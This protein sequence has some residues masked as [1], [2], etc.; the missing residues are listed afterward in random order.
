MHTNIETYWWLFQRSQSLAQDCSRHTG[1]KGPMPLSGIS[2]DPGK[3]SQPHNVQGRKRFQ[4]QVEQDLSEN[5]LSF[6]NI[7]PHSV[8]ITAISLSLNLHRSCWTGAFCIRPLCIPGFLCKFLVDIFL[9]EEGVGLVVFLFGWVFGV[10][11]LFLVYKK[12]TQHSVSKDRR[13]F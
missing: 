3:A 8:S 9:G 5:S 7:D 12:V 11:L 10:F 1:L 4:V 13:I 6:W 2:R